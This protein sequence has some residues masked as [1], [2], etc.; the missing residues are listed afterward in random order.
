MLTQE[1]KLS[2]NSDMAE[3]RSLLKKTRRLTKADC[4]TTTTREHEHWDS[5]ER[6]Q[7]LVH[8]LYDIQR[9]ILRQVHEG[10]RQGS[11]SEQRQRLRER[12]LFTVIQTRHH[13]RTC[14]VQIPSTHAVIEP[15]QPIQNQN[16]KEIIRTLERGMG[17]QCISDS[18]KRSEVGNKI[19]G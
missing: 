16:E 5:G 8:P 18:F 3:A 6:C 17:R 15:Y 11:G 1:H 19:N 9:I 2:N 13:Q 4:K 7:G 10:R 12:A 14:H